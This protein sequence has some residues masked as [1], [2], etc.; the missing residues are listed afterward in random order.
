MASTATANTIPLIG[1]DCT[2]SIASSP[3]GSH[4]IEADSA[5]HQAIPV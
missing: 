1:D 2:A 4:S 3:G 5:A